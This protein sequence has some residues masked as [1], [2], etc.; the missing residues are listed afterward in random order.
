MA[1]TLSCKGPQTLNLDFPVTVVDDLL[2]GHRMYEGEP[3]ADKEREERRQVLVVGAGLAGLSAAWALRDKDVLVCEIGTAPGGSSAAYDF[4]GMRFAQGA[5]YDLAYPDN[6]GP[7]VLAMLEAL[8][9]I[10][11]NTAA[12]RW[13]FVDTRYLIDPKQDSRTLGAKGFRR[14]PLPRIEETDR[15]EEILRGYQRKLVLPTRLITKGLHLLNK[16]S[17]QEFLTNMNLGKDPEFM[18]GL[19]YQMADDYGADAGRVSALA[20]LH[21]YGCRPYYAEK[22]PHFSPP[23]GNAYFADKLIDAL[24]PQTVRC[25]QLV[26]RIEAREK[27]FRVGVIDLEKNER[28]HVS[29][30]AVVYAGHKHGLRHVFPQDAGLFAHNR[31]APWVAVNLVLKDKLDTSYWQNEVVGRD[32]GFVGMVNSQSQA[33]EGNQTVL[34]AYF[35]LPEKN[36][37]DLLTLGMD[38]KPLLRRTLEIAG[39]SLEERIDTRVEHAFLKLHGHAMPIPTPGYLFQ[40]ANE[41]RSLPNLVHAGVDNGRLPLLFEALDSGLTAAAVLSKTKG[42]N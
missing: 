23:Q 13:D 30:D 19:N 8:N 3:P 41:K 34:T 9:I 2:R 40:D 5:H 39:Q 12:K 10:E 4:Q 27:D 1:S 6:W 42:S 32:P 26:T 36:R 35:Y 22:L 14:D 29:V 7:E 16:V 33:D 37:A 20:G 25:N 18:A 38:P 21:Y 15:F 24:P 31:Y 17:F 28:Y 11:H